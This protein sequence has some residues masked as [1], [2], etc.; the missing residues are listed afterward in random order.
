MKVF[1]LIV[2]SLCIPQ[3]IGVTVSPEFY[4]LRIMEDIK[5]IQNSGLQ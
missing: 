5:E 3:P 1:M 4:V 2:E